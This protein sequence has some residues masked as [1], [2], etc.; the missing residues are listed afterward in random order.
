[1]ALARLKKKLTNE[2]LWIY[3]LA[4]LRER[5]MYA[6][7]IHK[8]LSERFAIS[9]PI[10][11]V[12]LVLYRMNREGLVV[13]SDK[14]SVNGRP[15]RTYYKITEKGLRTFGEGLAFIKDMLGAIERSNLTPSDV[16]LDA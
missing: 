6:Y 2:N 5:P 1:M 14:I 15:E 4:L 12:Y 8:L 7:E 9:I 13:K 10:V 3:I 11:M 16:R